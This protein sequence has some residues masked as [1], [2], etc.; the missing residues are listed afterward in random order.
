MSSLQPGG[1]RRCHRIHGRDGKSYSCSGELISVRSA[2]LGGREV[3]KGKDEI[4]HSLGAASGISMKCVPASSLVTAEF[5]SSSSLDGRHE[6]PAVFDGAGTELRIGSA[7]LY[8]NESRSRCLT[9]ENMSKSP[10][11]GGRP[12]GRVDWFSPEYPR[13]SHLAGW[14]LST[15]REERK[16]MG[17]PGSAAGSAHVGAQDRRRTEGGGERPAAPHRISIRFGTPRHRS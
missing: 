5:C 11:E 3:T 8:R 15:R 10:H 4:S 14:M 17:D 9:P 7:Y 16:S 1:C 12:P 6:I 13:C 2:W